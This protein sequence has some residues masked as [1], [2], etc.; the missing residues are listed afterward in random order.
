MWNCGRSLH[1]AVCFREMLSA[2]NHNR[3]L[4]HPKAQSKIDLTKLQTNTLIP[5]YTYMGTNLKPL[6]YKN[7]VD[8]SCNSFSE[9]I[10]NFKYSKRFHNSLEARN[11]QQKAKK[12]Q[13]DYIVNC[14]LNSLDLTCDRK[15]LPYRDDNPTKLNYKKLKIGTICVLTGQSSRLRT[16]N[17]NYQD[18]WV[19]NWGEIWMRGAL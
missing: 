14:F 6:L 10:Q 16:P 3:V 11:D 5:T 1:T 4:R 15:P 8:Q 7:P 17:R 9:L 2:A 12:L 13:N 19:D 18:L